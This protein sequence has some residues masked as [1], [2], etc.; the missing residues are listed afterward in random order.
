MDIKTFAGRLWKAKNKVG[1]YELMGQVPLGGLAKLDESETSLLLERMGEFNYFRPEVLKILTQAG[2]LSVPVQDNPSKY[3]EYLRNIC[4]LRN[5]TKNDPI[6]CE[7][8]EQLRKLDR[9]RKNRLFS[10]EQLVQIV[11]SLTPKI[12]KDN[13]LYDQIV[14]LA[15]VRLSSFEASQ[16]T[17]LLHCLFQLHDYKV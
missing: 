9:K 5:I 14:Q 13:K 10:N 4:S 2:Q 12:K 16:L 17:R 1:F 3:V 15:M 11:E 7:Y 6:L 8:V